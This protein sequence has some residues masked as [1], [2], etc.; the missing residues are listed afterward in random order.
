MKRKKIL[1]HVAIVTLTSVGGN[2][3]HTISSEC[4]RFIERLKCKTEGNTAIDIS[5][6]VKPTVL[7]VI[8]SL[9]FGKHCES[10]DA[11]FKQIM[12][13]NDWFVEG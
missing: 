1:A 11:E 3:E 13:A 5:E 9:C 7:N 10:H 4:Q 12:Q 6:D 2:I 8:C